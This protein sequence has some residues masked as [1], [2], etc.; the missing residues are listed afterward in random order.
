[1]ILCVAGSITATLPPISELTQ[2]REPSLL[3]TA[4]RGRLS[5]STLSISL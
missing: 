4:Y 5:T 2:S 1:M 3:N